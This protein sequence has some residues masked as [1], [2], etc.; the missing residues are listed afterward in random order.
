MTELERPASQ[1]SVLVVEDSKTLRTEWLRSITHAYEGISVHE[2]D[3]FDGVAELLEG[4]IRP[5]VAVV[6][7]R[8]KSSERCPTASGLDVVK[9]L[10]ADCP[11]IRILVM[12]AYSMD[13]I[14]GE[15]VYRMYLTVAQDVEFLDKA[16][17][18][19]VATG[20]A[21]LVAC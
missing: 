16:P 6:D 10:K 8:L 5:A 18:G 4:G 20:F 9:R 17:E 13:T 3:S 19:V 14:D 15:K 2:A 12:S 11:N 1:I 7:H 21:A